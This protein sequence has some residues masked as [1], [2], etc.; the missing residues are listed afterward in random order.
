MN[1]EHE[2]N[3]F[4][5]ALKKTQFPRLTR[6]KVVLEMIANG[7]AAL[8]AILVYSIL[9]RFFVVKSVRNLWGLA[10]KKDKMLV[11]KDSFEW[12]SSVLIFIV[13][14]FVFTYVEDL[15]E[16]YLKEREEKR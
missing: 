14:L 13:A 2:W 15:I 3:S 1:W 4:L 10:A 7:V 5:K 11:S 16:R 8:C 6:K 12:M 9:R